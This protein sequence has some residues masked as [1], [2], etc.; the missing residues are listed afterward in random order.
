M[1]LDY[2]FEL[3][4]D[5]VQKSI[6]PILIDFTILEKLNGDKK[7]DHIVR[8]QSSFSNIEDEIFDAI[9]WSF[10]IFNK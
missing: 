1:I 8:D 4:K 10:I 7:D 3:L 6:I 2:D 9:N 5:L